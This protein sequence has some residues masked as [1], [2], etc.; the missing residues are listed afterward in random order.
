[1]TLEFKY[2]STNEEI[3]AMFYIQKIAHL[4]FPD[5]TVAVHQVGNVTRGEDTVAHARTELIPHTTDPVHVKIQEG[6]LEA[7]GDPDRLSTEAEAFYDSQINANV[8]NS[9]VQRFYRAYDRAGL[10]NRLAGFGR[11]DAVMDGKGVSLCRH[12]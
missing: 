6:F 11:Q 1:M 8:K 5:E 12:S 4:L 2:P 7:S 9:A 3:K 10:W